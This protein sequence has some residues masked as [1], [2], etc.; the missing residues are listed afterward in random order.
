MWTAGSLSGKWL[1]GEFP[2]HVSNVS[3]PSQQEGLKIKQAGQNQ[4]RQL[5]ELKGSCGEIYGLWN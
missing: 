3:C 1:A 5:H 4:C 2:Q